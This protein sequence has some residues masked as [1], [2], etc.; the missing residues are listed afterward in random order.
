MRFVWTLGCPRI[1]PHTKVCGFLQNPWHK[2]KLEI[3]VVEDGKENLAYAKQVYA[4]F[5]KEDLIRVNYATTYQDAEPLI[6]KVDA[7][8]LD[9]Y[10]PAKKADEIMNNFYDREIK[11]VR[12]KEELSNS[13]DF[14]NLTKKLCDK[15]GLEYWSKEHDLLSEQLIKEQEKIEDGI[16]RENKRKDYFEKIRISSGLL[17]VGFPLIK[18]LKDN[19]KQTILISTASTGHGKGDNPFYKLRQIG[20]KLMPSAWYPSDSAGT[21]LGFVS[22]AIGHPYKVRPGGDFQV[23]EIDDCGLLKKELSWKAALK[24]IAIATGNKEISEKIE[25]P[26]NIEEKLLNWQ[27]TYFNNPSA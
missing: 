25:L 13:E 9:L 15:K 18:R 14:I 3:L 8:I 16:S 2:E 12:F 22:E 10:F 26:E 7:G 5:E 20:E 24:G 17:P 27:K 21:L 23:N 1:H 19:S 11:S 4:P 6:K